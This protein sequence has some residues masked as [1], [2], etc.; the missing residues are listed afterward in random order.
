MKKFT[1]LFV[2]GMIMI[3]IGA[4][5]AGSMASAIL[6][7]NLETSHPEPGTGNTYSLTLLI[8]TNNWFSNAVGTQPAFY[9]VQN[10][11]LLS[12]ANFTLPANIP[13]NLT[14][15]NFDDGAA[16]TDPQ[17]ANVT[18]TVGNVIYI[19][20]DT[21][22]N[23][24]LPGSVTSGIKIGNAQPVS[25]VN[26]SNIAH[27]FTLQLGTSTVLN[28]PIVPL[29]VET[30]TFT[31]SDGVYQWHCMAACGSG[32]SG[33]NGAMATNGWMGGVVDVE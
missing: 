4:M 9:V 8:S 18:G 29:S 28:I 3:V 10:N 12:S 17:F 30:A 26:D 6:A 32:S 21:N 27:T 31:L 14:I 16:P 7:E 22:I 13:I 25:S 19:A 33:W 24:T 2:V 23:S 15:I 1:A 20:N 5:Y 11:H